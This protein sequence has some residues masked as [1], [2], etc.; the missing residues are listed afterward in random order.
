MVD[1]RTRVLT[2]GGGLCVSTGG[3]GRSV[4]SVGGAC[5]VCTGGA[6]IFASVAVVDQGC[7]CMVVNTANA[8][9]VEARRYVHTDG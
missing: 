1:A 7:A 5:S 3:S 2:V 6:R 4:G 8:N 9:S